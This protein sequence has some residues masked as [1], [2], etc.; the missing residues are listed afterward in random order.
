MVIESYMLYYISI[1]LLLK[2]NTIISAE[3][4]NIRNEVV[5]FKFNY[6]FGRVY[7]VDI[8]AVFGAKSRSYLV[9]S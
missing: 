3:L 8:I 7:C 2:L 5:I 4:V 1:L 6:L 9:S